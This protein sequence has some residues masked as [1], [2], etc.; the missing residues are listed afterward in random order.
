MLPGADF[1]DLRGYCSCLRGRGRVKVR[2]RV[3]SPTPPLAGKL[4]V[5]TRMYVLMPRSPYTYFSSISPSHSHSPLP[6]YVSRFLIA[7]RRWCSAV[8]RLQFRGDGG[9]SCWPRCKAAGGGGGPVF[10]RYSNGIGTVCNISIRKPIF[11]VA[12]QLYM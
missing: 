2:V 6:A 4:C 7:S 3:H 1:V 12:I 9:S 11:A 10:E 5:C 8:H